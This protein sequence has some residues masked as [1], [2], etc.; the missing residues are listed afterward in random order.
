VFDCRLEEGALKSA[1][2]TIGR[3]VSVNRS[4]LQSP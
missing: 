2:G 1:D 3:L 4:A